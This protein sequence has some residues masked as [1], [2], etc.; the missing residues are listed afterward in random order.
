M[1]SGVKQRVCLAAR[2]DFD[3]LPRSEEIEVRPARHSELSALADMANRRVPGVQTTEST[4]GRYLSFDPECILT[5]NRQDRLLGAMAFLYL[6]SRGYDA[7]ILDEIFLKCPDISL[8]AGADDEVSAIY[9]WANATSGRGI[10]GLGN[11][12]AYLRKPRFVSAD[13]F[14]QPSTI[15]GRDLLVATGFR[16]IASFQPDLWS[17]QRPWKRPP[18]QLP[19]PTVSARSFADARH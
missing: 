6:N 2:H 18:I 19:P 14:A 7:L 10:V 1:R 11:V 5:F 3:A 15:A 9:K 13:Y 4:L 12:A 16:Q 17:Y 8:L